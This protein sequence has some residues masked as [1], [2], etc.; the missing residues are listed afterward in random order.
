MGQVEVIQGHIADVVVIGNFHIVVITVA[1]RPCFRS[2]ADFHFYCLSEGVLPVKEHL[3]RPLYL[4]PGPCP[5]MIGGENSNQ[6]IGVMSDAVQVIT[7]LVIAGVV[8]GVIVHLVLQSS[9]QR[10]IICLGPQHIRILAGI[11][12]ASAAAQD[13]LC[14]HRTRGHDIKEHRHH[15]EQADDNEKALL[16]A[17]DKFSGPLAPLRRPFQRVGYPLRQGGCGPGCSLRRLPGTLCGGIL[18]FDGLF[19]LPA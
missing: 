17:H 13:G 14:Q 16:V 5:L 2:V 12:A 7:V 4:V 19:L 8:T 15:Q 18:L 9:L 11:G 6:H 1:V 10:G 3:Q